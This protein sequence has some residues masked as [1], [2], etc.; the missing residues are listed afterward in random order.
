M[1]ILHSSRSTHLDIENM[2]GN[3]FSVFISGL[4]HKN[5]T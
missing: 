3:T 5:K 4:L 1:N 2:T